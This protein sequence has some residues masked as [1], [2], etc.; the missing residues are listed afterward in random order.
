MSTV[1]FSVLNLASAAC[2]ALYS[3]ARSGDVSVYW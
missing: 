1:D 3:V 2:A